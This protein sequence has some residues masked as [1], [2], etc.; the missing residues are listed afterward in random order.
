MF[1][2]RVSTE[3]NQEDIEIKTKANKYVEELKNFNEQ[4]KVNE[5]I[6]DEIIK[7]LPNNKQC[8]KSGVKNEM[9]KYG[10]SPLLTKLVA[11]FINDKLQFGFKSKRSCNHAVITLKET[12]LCY[13]KKKKAV[14]SLEIDFSKA[15]DK[16]NPYRLFEKLMNIVLH[17]LIWL[18]IFNYYQS[19]VVFIVVN[20]DYS[21]WSKTRRSFVCKLNP[22]YVD[23]LIKIIKKSS[24][25]C[26]IKKIIIGILM[27]ADDT[28]ILAPNYLA[29]KRMLKI[30][31]EY[32][33]TNE[34]KINGEK[35]NFV[36]FGSKFIKNKY[37]TI[38][39]AG[40]IVERT[41]V[42]TYLGVTI[43]S[44]LNDK[45]HILSQIKK[46]QIKYFLIKPLGVENKLISK[47]I[48]KHIF[49]TFCKSTMFY[50]IQTTTLN[51][52]MYKKIQTSENVM[53]KRLLNLPKHS[54]T[55]KLR[56]ALNF[57]SAKNTIAIIKLKFFKSAMS[58]TLLNHIFKEIHSDTIGNKLKN[59][60][61]SNKSLLAEIMRILKHHR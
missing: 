59:K 33:K 58:H 36:I 48:K 53:I 29:L 35:S 22:I 14:F 45:H 30:I 44:T 5:D 34:I 28:F 2:E 12:L 19:I 25:P 61:M 51:K 9:L 55:T 57:N 47:K 10:R 20:K 7:N 13:K 54:K 60:S 16:I 11:I 31:E 23:D 52:S 42:F 4:Y 15:F 41:N 18:S 21:H 3:G 39:I 38:K 40:E 26:K 49:Q 8:G 24:Y 43:N 6:I 1:N 46:A 56:L 50:G 27:F 37:S 32:C 17:P